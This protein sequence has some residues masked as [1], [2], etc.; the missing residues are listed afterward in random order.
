MRWLRKLFGS[1]PYPPE[2]VEAPS[3]MDGLMLDSRHPLGHDR[4]S[5]PWIL[6][7][8]QAFDWHAAEYMVSRRRT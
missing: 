7:A 1:D 8:E 2:A 5:E 4:L 3:Y 6:G